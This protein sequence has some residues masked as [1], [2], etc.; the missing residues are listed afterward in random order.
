MSYLGGPNRYLCSAL[1][2]MRKQ[3]EALNHTSLYRYKDITKLMIEEIQ[4]HANNMEAALSDWDDLQRMRQAKKKI[5]KELKALEAKKKEEP[6]SALELLGI[7][8]DD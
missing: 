8:D 3:L 5:K 6:K 2:E 4:T 1:D 7:G